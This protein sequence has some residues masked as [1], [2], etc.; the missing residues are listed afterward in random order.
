M[1]VV[2]NR[3]VVVDSD[4]RFDNLCGSHLQSQSELYH[5]SWWHYTLVIDYVH[6]DDQTQPFEMT[7]GFKP[8]TISILPPSKWSVHD[9]FIPPHPIS[10]FLVICFELPITRIP[11]SQ[12]SAVVKMIKTWIHRFAVKNIPKMKRHRSIVPSAATYLHVAPSYGTSTFQHFF[13][14]GE[15]VAF[16]LANRKRRTFMP[17]RQTNHILIFL[18]SGCLCLT[19]AGSHLKEK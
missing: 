2:L 18:F 6:P 3:T 7:P 16:Y 4:W 19:C 13:F 14:S 9:T 5:V 8:F 10:L 15:C 1:N 11:D 12:E 17:L